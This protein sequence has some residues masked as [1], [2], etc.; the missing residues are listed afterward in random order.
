[1]EHPGY[2][3]ARNMKT[4][5][6]SDLLSPRASGSSNAARS[7]PSAAQ[8]PKKNS[9]QDMDVS[10]NRGWFPPK[11]MV[12][13]MENPMNKWMIWGFSHYF[14]KH[15]YSYK[16]GKCNR[17]KQNIEATSLG[18]VI[19]IKPYSCTNQDVILRNSCNW[20]MDYAFGIRCACS[21]LLLIHPSCH[22]ISPFSCANQD[23]STHNLRA[24]ATQH[25]TSIDIVKA[26][27]KPPTPSLYGFCRF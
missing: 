19:W 13:I 3:P 26:Y 22:S 8:H 12:K 21:H 4:C 25:D 17:N 10:K 6:L 20:K 1:M 2:D 15:P 16:H 24:H 14:W 7:L 9:R 27:P 5:D 11:W 18:C 23:V